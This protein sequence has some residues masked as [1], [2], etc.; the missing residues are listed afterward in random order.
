VVGARTGY[1]HT[2]AGKTKQHDRA[3]KWAV[4]QTRK[5]SSL[6]RTCLSAGEGLAYG[7][8]QFLSGKGY[9]MDFNDLCREIELTVTG[10]L[11]VHPLDIE[12]LSFLQ[13]NYDVCDDV[14]NYHVPHMET[15][16]G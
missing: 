13:W 6:I 12:S 15:D 3:S 1:D 14:L 16:P 4:D 8:Q 2:T 9:C 10:M 5:Q 7:F 11:F